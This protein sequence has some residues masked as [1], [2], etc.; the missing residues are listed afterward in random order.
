MQCINTRP[1][2]KLFNAYK[3]NEF[4]NLFVRG[5][6]CRFSEFNYLRIIPFVRDKMIEAAGWIK[7]CMK[8]NI[9]QRND[10]M[11]G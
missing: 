10:K 4:L 5:A 11:R 6:K 9:Y 7:K 2:C 1:T 8:V 3:I